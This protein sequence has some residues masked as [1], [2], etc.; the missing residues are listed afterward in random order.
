MNKNKKIELFNVD[1]G[2]V[3]YM[4]KKEAEKRFGKDEFDEMLKGYLPNW[5]V[6]GLDE[7]EE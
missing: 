3:F 4:T 2:N 5:A 7:E 6:M 1:T